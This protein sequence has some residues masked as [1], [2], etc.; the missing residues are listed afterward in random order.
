MTEEFKTVSFGGCTIRNISP[1]LDEATVPPVINIH[2]SLEEALLLG[3]AIDE[4]AREVNS[5]NMKTTAGK[6]A[7]ILVALRLAGPDQR[8]IDVL[9]GKVAQD[10]SPEGRRQERRGGDD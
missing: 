9:E 3:L 4:C 5:R 2:L 6:R 1:R 10:P 8:R 7:S